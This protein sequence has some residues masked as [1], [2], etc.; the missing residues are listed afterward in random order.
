MARDTGLFKL[1]NPWPRIGW[2]MAAGTIAVSVVLGFLI[3][4]RFQQNGPQL[5]T[6][7]AICTAFGLYSDSSPAGEPQPPVRT[8]TRIA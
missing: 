4:P 3:L 1:T 5:D 8:P 6:W 2:W 7:T